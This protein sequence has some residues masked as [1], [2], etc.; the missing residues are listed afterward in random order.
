M[1]SLK[2]EDRIREKFEEMEFFL[3]VLK[4]EIE[5]KMQNYNED[6][7]LLIKYLYGNMPFSDR[8]N[9]PF[10]TY[11]DYA[12]HGA[13]LWKSG[14]YSKQI[15]E[16]LFLK[17][18]VF[19][20]INTEDISPCRTFFYES[21][22]ERIAKKDMKSATLEV[23]YW[24]CEEATYQTTDDRTAS[25]M[26][27]YRGAIGRCGEESTFTASALRSIGIP[28]RQ[29]Y[30]P[31]W[32]HCDD[33]HAWV[34]VWC[35]GMWHF[36][37]ACEPEERLNTGWFVNASSRAMMILSKTFEHDMSKEKHLSFDAPEE[38]CLTKSG[39]LTLENQ[40]SRYA[41]TATLCIAVLDENLQPAKGVTVDFEILNFSEFTP[42]ASGITDDMGR[43]SIKTGLSSIHVNAYQGDNC[44][45]Q[46]FL[47]QDDIY[48]VMKLKPK[49]NSTEEWEEFDF[50]APTDMPI[51]RVELTP[52]EKEN[53]KKKL[54]QATEKRI[55]KISGFYA[56]NGKSTYHSYLYK[57][58]GNY[59]ELEN[60]LM[61]RCDTNCDKEQENRNIELKTALLNCISDKDFR[62]VTCEILLDHLHYGTLYAGQYP[63]DIFENYV[64]NPRIYLEK[65]Q[66]YRQCILRFF[67][68]KEIAHF[69]KK[70]SCIWTWIDTHI[71]ECPQLEYDALLTSVKGCL[72]GK[73]ANQMSKKILFVA[74][75]RTLGIPARLRPTDQAI[76]YYDL[77]RFCTVV[78]GT[79]QTA[80]ITLISGDSTTWTYLQNWSIAIYKNGIYETLKIT[81]PKI[82]HRATT[83]NVV[84]GD[85]RIL[86]SNR[87][88]NGNQFAKSL[89]F[90]LEEKKE[91][92]I[93]LTQREANLSDMLEEVAL[94][95]LPLFDQS[96]Q[97]RDMEHLFNKNC[98]IL[99]WLEES[100]EPTE[101]ILN[102][103]YVHRKEF[104]NHEKQIFFVIRHSSALNDP[105]IFKC[106]Q[107]LPNINVYYDKK[108]SHVSALARRMYADPDKLPLILMV[109]HKMQGIYATSGYN[110][111]TASLLLRILDWKGV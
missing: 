80:N 40:L 93:I 81:N 46:N 54:Q 12:K 17:N 58:R 7:C 44:A 60:F 79:K 22:H 43:I 91:K 21:L 25:P 107:A 62:D 102:E 3:P 37:G 45:Q 23:N 30:V 20:R 90:S 49:T 15:P 68:K 38:G 59:R 105:T 47:V 32:S 98:A 31:K 10:E 96:G 86:I 108:F 36:L 109:D 34:E 70:P 77:Q 100:K 29:V 73:A 103:L 92:S 52:K 85:Y 28:A 110:V 97:S 8:V 71:R 94:E 53:G 4:K 87:L 13:F 88:P 95:K 11:L 16:E 26:T 39:I 57:S 111:G 74:I 2:C 24:C 18:V 82:G 56:E 35:D 64:L 78:N 27:V 106:L 14:I 84:P 6:V 33:N 61:E 104:K 48:H 42:I 72:K 99:L 51:N 65:L 63:S 66:T 50:A 41:K 55:K 69:R 1:F 9:Y 76:E 75:C 5:H 89:T 67:T 101:H 19:H 83:L